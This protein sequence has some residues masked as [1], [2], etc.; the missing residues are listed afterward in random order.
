VT[1]ANNKPWAVGTFVDLASGNNEA[2]MLHQGNS[3]WSIVNAP[4]PGSGSNILGGVAASGNTLWAVGLYDNAGSN[5]P[6][7]ERHPS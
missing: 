5:L 3:G 7:I 1:T 4:N 6:L 2:L